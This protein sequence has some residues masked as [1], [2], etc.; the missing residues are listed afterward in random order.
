M[1]AGFVIYT[2][3]IPPNQGDLM[4]YTFECEFLDTFYKLHWDDGEL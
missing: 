4:P 2:K 3:V 1:M